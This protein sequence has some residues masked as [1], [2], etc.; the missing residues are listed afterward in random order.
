MHIQRVLIGAAIL[1]L[2]FASTA[3]A[4]EP[5]PPMPPEPPEPPA[6]VALPNDDATPPASDTVIVVPATETPVYPVD[7]P[8]DP[9][10]DPY[11]PS[12]EPYT[13]S[14]QD[15]DRTTNAVR[16]RTG[17]CAP[18]M[19]PC[20]PPCPMPCPSP[21]DPC[22]APCDPC[23]KP[24]YEGYGGF[25]LQ[26]YPGLG[27]GV[28]FGMWFAR[29]SCVNWAWEFSLN[30]QDL[31]TD[32]NN[33]HSQEGGKWNSA[34]LGVKASFLPQGN[35]HPVLRAGLGWGVESGDADNDYDI[36]DIIDTP[37]QTNYYG[38]FFGVGWEFDLFKG[39]IT[40]GPEVYAF[41]GYPEEGDEWTWTGTFAWHFLVNF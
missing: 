36:G 21:C 4:D 17:P 11:A 39:R 27:F 9:Y 16:M 19:A 2:V 18:S 20:A 15:F 6:G 28:E 10:V 33:I 38:G 41:A 13:P 22:P 5:A 8:M 14:V 12:N 31:Y 29:S 24:C 37:G 3:I 40:T 7:Q 1:V 25:S 23:A 35:S 32:F 26:A 34:R 30:Y